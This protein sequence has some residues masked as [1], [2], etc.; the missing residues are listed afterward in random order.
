MASDAESD[1]FGVFDFAEFTSDDFAQ[2][3]RD[4]ASRFLEPSAPQLDLGGEPCFAAE[5]A[6]T[7]EISEESDNDQAHEAREDD[8]RADETFEFD[9]SL[10]LGALAEED[11]LAIDDAVN[12]HFDIP[13]QYGQPKEMFTVDSWPVRQ[14][15]DLSL[16]SSSIV[17]LS[18]LDL[19]SYL[20]PRVSLE[21]LGTLSHWLP[22][23]LAQTVIDLNFTPIDAKRSRLIR[24]RFVY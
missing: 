11:F 2:I 18:D 23:L 5:E 17:L 12:L 14:M 21:G 6:S 4:I 16:L 9:A 24:G 13:R 1:G 8:Y 20:L 15:A 19:H 7:S 10:D 3:D 22:P